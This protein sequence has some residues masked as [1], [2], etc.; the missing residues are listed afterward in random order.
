MERD[1]EIKR[2][3]DQRERLGLDPLDLSRAKRD[4]RAAAKRARA[5]IGFLIKSG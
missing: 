3:Q 4:S 2:S 1:E 5:E